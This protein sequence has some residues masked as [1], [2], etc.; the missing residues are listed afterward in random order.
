MKQR[1][2]GLDL[3]KVIAM[4]WIIFFHF[5]NYSVLNHAEPN[6][7]NW[8]LLAGAGLGG[9][10]GNCIFVLISG[11]FLYA[12]KFKPITIL[13]LTLEVLF[14][15]LIGGLIGILYGTYH[16]SGSFLLQ[17]LFPVNDYWF[18]DYYILLYL[19]FP[20]I[21]W[22]LMYMSSKVHFVVIVLTYI[23]LN[24]IPSLQM[25]VYTGK[26]MNMLSVYLTFLVL[27]ITGA[28]V[29]RKENGISTYKKIFMFA[30]IILVL[31]EIVS[32]YLL[33]VT[34]V[35]DCTFFIWKMDK[36]LPV[37]TAFTLFMAFKNVK[38]NSGKIV[39]ELSSSV[40]GVYL[41][42]TGKAWGFFKST[43]LDSNLSYMHAYMIVHMLISAIIVFGI[44][45]IV[46]LFRKRCLEIPIMR[47]INNCSGGNV[48]TNGK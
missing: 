15:S 1:N 26:V 4:F 12:K 2:Y 7:I 20:L 45:E 39:T 47:T 32:V 5:G 16:M 9:G 37:A 46:E 31:I 34:G 17:V 18:F 13:K 8:F 11:Y 29:R 22:M 44:A 38:I 48:S 24:I 36:G 28:Y 43:I 19:M 25:S 21:N 41:L 40:F 6:T 33:R 35:Q 27:Y 3:L 30:G 10:V 14:Y 23:C 42:H